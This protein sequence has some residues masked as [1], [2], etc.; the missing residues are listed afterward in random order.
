MDLEEAACLVGSHETNESRH[1]G[2]DS[3][4]WSVSRGPHGRSQAPVIRSALNGGRGFPRGAAGVHA[5][6]DVDTAGVACEVTMKAIDQPR[7]IFEFLRRNRG[8][9]YCDDCLGSAT[10]VDRHHV[11]SIGSTFSLFP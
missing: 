4:T 7:L 9:D 11:N 1:R 6:R 3:V 10:G 8:V 2:F 5:G